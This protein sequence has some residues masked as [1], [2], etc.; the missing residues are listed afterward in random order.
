MTIIRLGFLG[1]SDELVAIL[2]GIVSELPWNEN[3]ENDIF[4]G[5]KPQKSRVKLPWQKEAKLRCLPVE[6]TARVRDIF[7]NESIKRRES[8]D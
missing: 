7:P 4:L 3:L 8:H 1:A 2:S 6:E 5:P